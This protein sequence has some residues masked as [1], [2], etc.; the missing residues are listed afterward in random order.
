MWWWGSSV[1][2]LWELEYSFI[3]DPL[4]TWMVAHESVASMGQIEQFEL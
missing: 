1:V 2:A 4:W 3:I